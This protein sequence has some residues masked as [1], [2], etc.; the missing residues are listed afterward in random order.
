VSATEW[1]V[2]SCAA[3]AIGRHA[4]SVMSPTQDFMDVALYG[5]DVTGA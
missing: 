4:A 3:A 2:E 1:V 5:V